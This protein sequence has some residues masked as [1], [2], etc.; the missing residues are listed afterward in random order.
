MLTISAPPP[1]L[2]QNGSFES[3]L[4]GEWNLNVDS[5]Q[6]ASATM[7]RTN[8]TAADGTYSIQIDA[9]STATGTANTS[10]VQLWQ[11]GFPVQ[12]GQVYTLQ[13]FAKADN[14][15]T[16][17]LD[18]VQNGGSSSNYGLS[19]SY[20]LRTG[21]IHYVVYFQATATDPAARLDFNLGDHTGNTWIDGVVLR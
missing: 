21:W 16:V 20:P 2:I 12:Q 5:S 9:T 19:K 10:A 3:P 4:T 18:V 13:F 7:Q 6:G 17:V 11:A 8:S 15:G 1:N 14:P